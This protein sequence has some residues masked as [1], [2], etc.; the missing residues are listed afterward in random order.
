MDVGAPHLLAEG[1]SPVHGEAVSQRTPIPWASPPRSDETPPF[2]ESGALCVSRRRGFSRSA[3][4]CLRAFLRPCLTDERRKQASLNHDVPT[5]FC[6]T[7]TTHGHD[8]SGYCSSPERGGDPDSFTIESC[9]EPCLLRGHL[10]ESLSGHPPC[11]MLDGRA[12]RA[13]PRLAQGGRGA[14]LSARRGPSEHGNARETRR[15][16]NEATRAEGLERRT[17]T[18]HAR[19]DVRGAYAFPSSE[20]SEHPSSSFGAWRLRS[21]GDHGTRPTK[22]LVP[23]TPREGWC[24]SDAQDAGEPFFGMAWTEIALQRIPPLRLAPNHESR[25][26]GDA[27]S[28]EELPSSRSARFACARSAPHGRGEQKGSF[29]WA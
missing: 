9:G 6:N 5:E 26:R 29:G 18:S 1:A 2:A 28:A 10:D 11:A 13:K 27:S 15:D 17:C 20:T 24:L 22:S 14:T 7:F 3:S 25:S 4:S 8:L 21:G 16:S 23:A 19:F 12:S